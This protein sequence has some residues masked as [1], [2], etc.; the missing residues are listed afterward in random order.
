MYLH[1]LLQQRDLLSTTIFISHLVNAPAHL[2][3]PCSSSPLYFVA[4]VFI[5]SRKAMVTGEAPFTKASF[6]IGGF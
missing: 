2:T 1:F 4:H 5:S 6:S 3:N